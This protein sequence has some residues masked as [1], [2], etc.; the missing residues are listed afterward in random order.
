MNTDLFQINFFIQLAIRS[1]SKES[2]CATI[3]YI[4]CHL[5]EI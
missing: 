2:L 1:N 3:I 4:F 5:V